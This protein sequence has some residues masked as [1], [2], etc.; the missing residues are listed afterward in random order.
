M[1]LVNI[2]TTKFKKLEKF[3]LKGVELFY[4]MTMFF[5]SHEMQTKFQ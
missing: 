5:I 4:I 1:Y 2:I 3:I